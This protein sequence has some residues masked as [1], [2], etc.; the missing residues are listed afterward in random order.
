[1][2]AMQGIMGQAAVA[3]SAQ[4][5]PCPLW[6]V[7]QPLNTRA[8]ITYH[9]TGTHAKALF[10]KAAAPVFKEYVDSALHSILKSRSK[11][12]DLSDRQMLTCQHDLFRAWLWTGD[13]RALTIEAVRCR[14]YG[15]SCALIRRTKH[16]LVQLVR[17]P[18][19]QIVS[20]YLYHRGDTGGATGVNVAEPWLAWPIDGGTKCTGKKDTSPPC[21]QSLAG[22]SSAGWWLLFKS[23]RVA[24]N[25]SHTREY[26]PTDP[27]AQM[28][29]LATG[30][31]QVQHIKSA[32]PPMSY[33]P[34]EAYQDYLRRVPPREGLLVEALRVGR[35]DLPLMRY[36][37]AMVD[38]QLTTVC[39]EELS[40]G[41]AACRGAWARII[42]H[43]D[44]P[45]QLGRDLLG[46]AVNATCRTPDGGP[47]ASLAG[48]TTAQMVADGLSAHELR[49]V[50]VDLD[51][52]QLDGAL[53]RHHRLFNC[54][55]HARSHEIHV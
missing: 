15:Q 12:S 38:H 19:A 33:E 40:R 46:V 25:A 48:V 51:A 27:T 4:R 41:R 20:S 32:K 17:E 35:L 54:T 39:L 26:R 2:A 53:L 16:L 43:L 45:A 18:F 13:Q 36:E 52:T 11:T 34:Q 22:R 44:Y 49:E 30:Y 21:L 8:I 47:A 10:V 3:T 24:F 6:T 1:M 23:A 14:A 37:A 29:Y 50:L 9:K 7:F 28:L 31:Q 5:E 42:A 55:E